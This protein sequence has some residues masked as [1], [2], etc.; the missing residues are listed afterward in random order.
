MHEVVDDPAAQEGRPASFTLPGAPIDRETIQ[1]WQH[2]RLTRGS[3]VPAPRLDLA[4]H[5]AQGPRGQALHD[6]HRAATHANLRLQETPMSLKVTTIMRSR[7]QSNALKTKP[8][9]RAGLMINGGGYQGKTE[10]VCEAAAAF[11]DFWR[12]LHQQL[13]PDAILG[14]RDL[15][16]P[17][18]YVQTPV[19]ATPKS[20]CEAIL[21]FYGHPL[22]YRATLPQLIRSVRDS[23]RDHG[24][25]VL[26]ID[27]ITR[28]K[29]HRE[30]DQDTL[31]LLRSLMSM[32][33]TLILI[34][35]G[36]RTSG[37]LGEGRHDLRTGQWVFTGRRHTKKN[38]NDEA[39]T[40]TQRRFDLIDLDPFD[41]STPETINAWLAHLAGIEDQLRLFRAPPSM[42]T[43][44]KMPEYLFARTAGI[45]GLL[46]RLIEDGCTAAIGTGR[47]LLDVHVQGD[48]VRVI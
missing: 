43:T 15:W 30:A 18:A 41:Y 8:T 24:T 20:L 32:Q 5:R 2:F 23:L 26:I 48:G 9:T 31:D 13:N 42:L 39:A 6:L 36:I 40:Q 47:E 12:L 22:G 33:V 7:I 4:A 44:G 10:T 19:T 29:M 45:V 3:F 38:G 17:V 37:L 1:G 21:S 27:D 14:T 16:A 35:V 46:E 28:L 11:E 34:G 25:R